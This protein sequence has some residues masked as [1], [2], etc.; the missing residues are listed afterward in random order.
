VHGEETL[1]R[2]DF[3]NPDASRD[4]WLMSEDGTGTVTFRDGYNFINMTDQTKAGEFTDVNIHT[5]GNTPYRYAGMEIRLRCS[6]DNR[7]VSSVGGGWRGWGFIDWAGQSGLDFSSASPESGE[8]NS[9]FRARS[10]TGGYTRLWKPITD[11]DITQW[12]TYTILWEPDNGTFL[13][14]G[15]VVATTDRVPKTG[16][17][18]AVFNT[19]LALE[20]PYYQNGD[21][22]ITVPFDSCIQVDY[23]HIYGVPEMFTLGLLASILIS[24]CSPVQR[25]RSRTP[26]HSQSH[27][28]PS[29]SEEKVELGFRKTDLH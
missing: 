21:E 26:I 23:I 13:V 16:M 17:V 24:L 15:V 7:L 9:G 14:D 18:A 22:L 29:C 20:K 8:E 11:I 2:D 19:N 25:Q 1:L 28:V 3:G 12:H 6:D 4:I 27:S 10:V 5:P